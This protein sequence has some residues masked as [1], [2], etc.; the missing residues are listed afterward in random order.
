MMSEKIELL[1]E[2]IVKGELTEFMTGAVKKYYFACPYDDMPTDPEQVFDA[3][4]EYYSETNSNTIWAEFQNALIEMTKDPAMV[5]ISLY[6]LMNYLYYRDYK[7]S[8]F[9]DLE[10]VITSI[11]NGLLESKE[12]LILNKNW[13]GAQ[14][15]NGQWENANR[16]VKNINEEF[17]LKINLE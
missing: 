11:K 10:L 16:L 2:A 4:K 13:T 3:I 14:F 6:Y 17:N 1:K 5:W 9:I 7:K 12:K 8:E 15:E